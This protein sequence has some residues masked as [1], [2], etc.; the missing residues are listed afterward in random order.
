MAGRNK[1]DRKESQSLSFA[2]QA[3][4][5]TATINHL[6]AAIEHDSSHSSRRLETCLTQV[7]RLRQRLREAFEQER[8]HSGAGRAANGVD[9]IRRIHVGRPRLAEPERAADFTMDVTEE[10]TDAAIR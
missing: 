9:D 3:K 6:L 1:G 10:S 5:I 2:E 4:S 7:D 8:A